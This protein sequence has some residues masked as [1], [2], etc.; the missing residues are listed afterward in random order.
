[1]YISILIPLYNGAEYL[2]EAIN[3]V[4]QQSYKKWEIIIG[5]NGHSLNSK[6]FSLATQ[7]EDN[8]IR[9]IEYP[10]CKGKAN[11]LNRMVHDCKYGV[12]CL[13]DV[14]D[15]WHPHKLETQIEFMKYY[16]IVGTHCQYF[17]SKKNSP[18]L[19]SKQIN[20]DIFL[21]KNP[22]INSS[23]MLN[24]L[25][26]HWNDVFLEDYDLWLRLNYERKTFYNVP[27]KLTL[28]RLHKES[29]Y[30]NTNYKYVAELIKKWEIIYNS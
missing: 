21:K 9:V 12:I 10:N 3:S 4:K 16:D 1:M 20:Y 17:G 5:I 13:L 15:M 18:N 30:N 8:Q 24:R 11:T 22:I 2:H 6:I 14:D 19:P 7:Y 29:Y 23:C 26:A 28:H 25:D 27:I